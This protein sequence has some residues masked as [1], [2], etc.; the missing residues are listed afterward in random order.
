MSPAKKVFKK[1]ILTVIGIGCLILGLC[2]VLSWWDYV[3]IL[4]KSFIGMFLAV[5]GLFILFVIRE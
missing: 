1:V 2:L 4:F 3:T 5:L